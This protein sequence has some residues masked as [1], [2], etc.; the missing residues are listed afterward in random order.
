MSQLGKCLLLL[1]DDSLGVESIR[2]DVTTMLFSVNAAA[3]GIDDLQVR[4]EDALQN[5]DRPLVR[6]SDQLSDLHGAFEGGYTAL[7]MGFTGRY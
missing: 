6:I 3:N 2:D 1:S 7:I 4:L 5:L